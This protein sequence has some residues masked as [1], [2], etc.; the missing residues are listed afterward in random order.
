MNSKGRDRN[1]TAERSLRIMGGLACAAVVAACGGS[2]GDGTTGASTDSL[3]GTIGPQGGEL[4]GRRGSALEGVHLVVPA[5]ALSA[6]TDIS[7]RPVDNDTPLP[8]TAVRCGPDVH[9]RARGAEA[10][11]ARDPH[12]ARSTRSTVSAQ[13]R[14]DD[15]VKVWVARRQRRGASSSRPTAPPAR[16]RSISTRS[17]IAAAGVNPPAPG[18]VVHFSF[19]PNPKFARCLAGSIPTTRSKPPDRRGRPSCAARSTTACSS[20]ARTSSPAC[21]STSS[22][23]RTTRSSRRRGRPGFTNFGL[24]W[25]QSDLEAESNGSM[26]AIDPDDPARP[27]LRLRPARSRWPRRAR[28]RSASGSTTRTTPSACGFDVDQA[29]A[30]QRRAQGRPARDDHRP[31]RDDRPR[32]A[33]HQAGHLGFA[34][35][36]AIHDSRLRYRIRRDAGGR[37]DLRRQPAHDRRG[38]RSRWRASWWCSPR[39]VRRRTPS[40]SGPAGSS[41]GAASLDG[42]LENDERISRRHVRITPRARRLGGRGP[43]EP[44]RHLRRRPGASAAGRVVCSAALPSSGSAARCS[45]PLD[46]VRSLLGHSAGPANT[47][48][49][50]RR[51]HP[52]ARLRR[53][54]A[55]EPLE[56]HAP[57][58]RRERRRQGARRARLSRR[59]A[60]RCNERPVRRSQ[61]RR[62]PRGPG[63]APALR[64]PQGRVLGGG[65]RR[66][67]GTS[68][69]PT[70]A[71]SSSTRSP[72][73]TR[74]VQAKLLRVLETREVLPL[75]RVATEEGRDRH[76]RGEPS[77]A[78][79]RGLCGAVPR[80]PLLSYRQTRGAHPAAARAPRRDSLVRLARASKSLPGA[81]GVGRVRRGLRPPSVARERSR[82]PA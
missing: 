53:D 59:A 38:V 57:G 80:G 79:R 64:R 55:G 65:E 15:E 19:K 33:V 13:D 52:A 72:S 69:R 37:R 43:R 17:T 82:A 12:A 66:R 62:H 56:R 45:G 36:A 9:D 7:I 24:A 27:D 6:D 60:R 44:Q 35:R 51:R 73:S 68:R 21:S 16:S 25:Y 50:S 71:R 47:E 42:L 34:R 10:R 11:G 32:P 1:R 40:R 28:S 76:L 81:D 26:H 20:R 4:V 49:P 48:G 58:P 22:P 74:S 75:G 29:D 18:D 31:R 23:C 67:R 39:G 2:G 70:R 78:A 30:V 41:S 46:D 8:A 77:K 54:R 61:L 5:G 14:F 3:H 63:R